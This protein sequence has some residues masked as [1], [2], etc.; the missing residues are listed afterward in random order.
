MP[1]MLAGKPPPP[2]LSPISTMTVTRQR[3]I[4]MLYLNASLGI[5]GWAL[6]EGEF[7]YMTRGIAGSQ[8]KKPWN[9]NF[10]GAIV[11]FDQESF[12]GRIQPCGEPLSAKSVALIPGSERERF[13][14]AKTRNYWPEFPRRVGLVL[15]IL[16]PW[17]TIITDEKG[18]KMNGS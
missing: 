2:L 17:F 9:P 4:W 8:S 16:T 13:S 7:C 18:R 11:L 6:S 5:Q 1:E 10:L 14:P 15:T 12:K 3:T